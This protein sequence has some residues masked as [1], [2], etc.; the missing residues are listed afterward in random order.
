MNETQKKQVTMHKDFFDRCELAI[1]YGFYMEAILIEYAAMES[2]LEILLGVLGLPC[3]KH[4]EDNLRKNVNISHRIACLKWLVENS[5]LFATSKLDN[6]YFEKMEKWV[7]ERNKYV[8]GLYKN[9]GLYEQRKAHARE[10]AKNGKEYCKLLYNETH[11]LRR[12]IKKQPL[13]LGDP[14]AC[15]SEKCQLYKE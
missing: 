4:L 9:E 7:K 6:K 1:E 15:R 2:R 10:L 3:N 11:R 13:L 14:V 8:H 5:A 12:A